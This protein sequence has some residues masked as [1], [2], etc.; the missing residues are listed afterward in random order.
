MLRDRKTNWEKLRLITPIFAALSMF[1]LTAMWN[2]INKLSDKMDSVG[3]RV[4]ALEAQVR[5]LLK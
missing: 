3:Q 4:A 1:I 2:N 5:I